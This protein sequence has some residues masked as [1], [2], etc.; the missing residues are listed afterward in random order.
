[1][2]NFNKR[3]AILK[4]FSL[5]FGLFIWMYVI[6]SAEVEIGH[7][8]TLKIEIPDKLSIKNHIPKEIIYRIK[9]PGIF[10]RKFNDDQKT[11]VISVKDYYKKNKRKFT[12][13]LEKLK[14]KLPF[15][16]ELL[17]VEPR[18]IKLELEKSYS[19]SVVIKPDF[20]PGILERY[21]IQKLLLNP[22][23]VKI[24]GP[25]SLVKQINF[26]KTKELDGL[27]VGVNKEI[28]LGLVSSDDRVQLSQSEVTASMV[29][30]SKTKTRKFQNIPIIFQSTALIKYASQKNISIEVEG[31]DSLID[32]LRPES[33]QVVASIPKIEKGKGEFTIELITELPQGIKT[34]EM[35]PKT[36]KV[37]VE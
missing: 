2:K 18:Q 11:L 19:K 15:G 21:R 10:A 35:S 33:I 16:L 17:Q 6:S 7:E 5:L 8:V 13:N 30:I 26:I 31:N 28:S 22:K 3:K 4:V 29:L 23:K 25:R 14:M 32:K 37:K 9:G 34:L 20:S 1:M 36:I 24:V 12:I 27:N